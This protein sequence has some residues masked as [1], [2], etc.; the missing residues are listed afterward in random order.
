MVPS[1]PA[2]ALAQLGFTDLE[3]Q[4][5]V[6]LLQ[7]APVTA[8]RLAQQVGKAAANVYKAVESLRKKGAI[9]VDSENSL[10][11]PVPPE[12][13]LRIVEG[14]FTRAKERAARALAAVDRRQADE[15]L[16]QLRTRDQV[17][18]RARALLRRAK[19][20]V[21]GDLFPGPAEELRSDLEAT[22]ARGCRV[23]L[24]TYRPAAIAGAVTEFVKEDGAHHLEKWPGQW[25]NLVGDAQEHLL[26][27]LRDGGDGVHCAVWGESK[28]LSVLFHS[29]IK[30]EMAWTEMSNAVR[31]GAPLAEL[32]REHERLRGLV[33]HASLPGYSGLLAQL[34]VVPNEKRGGGK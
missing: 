7:E 16:Y 21:L 2:E 29:G 17:M 12:D 22:A 33:E 23:Y 26:A 30:C 32:R 20:M 18:E 4:V 19:Q 11:R 27:L 24:Q 6:A 34:G 15:R 28:Y 13:L 10:C 31:R 8:Y 9:L 3:A 14:R 1:P 5:Y 25:L